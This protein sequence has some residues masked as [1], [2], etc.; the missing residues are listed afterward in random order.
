MRPKGNAHDGHVKREV[1]FSLYLPSLVLHYLIDSSVAVFSFQ[2][3]TQT[4]LCCLRRIS[5]PIF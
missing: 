1:S 5:K 2:L 4:P 3:L